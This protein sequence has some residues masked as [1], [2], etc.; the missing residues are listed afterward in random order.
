MKFTGKI[1]SSLNK[2][3]AIVI[4]LTS[5]PSVALIVALHIIRIHE[6]SKETSV[7][8]KINIENIKV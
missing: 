7:I 3:F 1:K 5:P 8:L 6:V 2:R 4:K